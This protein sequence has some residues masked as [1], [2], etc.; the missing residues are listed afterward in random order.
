MSE[1]KKSLLKR[2]FSTGKEVSVPVDTKSRK[3]PLGMPRKKK[4]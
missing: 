4:K 3:A 2:I 1:R